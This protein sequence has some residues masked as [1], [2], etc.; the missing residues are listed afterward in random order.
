MLGTI[1]TAEDS[2]TAKHSDPASSINPNVGYDAARLVH[3]HLPQYSRCH[4][5]PR[6]QASAAACHGHLCPTQLGYD[7][8]CQHG[9][10]LMP[11]CKP[12]NSFSMSS[13]KPLGVESSSTRPVCAHVA[14]SVSR[15]GSADSSCAC[16]Q[17]SA[18]AA[19]GCTPRDSVGSSGAAAASRPA[20]FAAALHASGALELTC[21]LT[22]CQVPH[23]ARPMTPT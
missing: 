14:A 8:L 12:P 5:A 6:F 21:R 10:L 17:A 4:G 9:N 2:T 19:A 23:A 7:V 18:A 20:S 15:R 1:P 22:L 3:C 11:T 13:P 16:R